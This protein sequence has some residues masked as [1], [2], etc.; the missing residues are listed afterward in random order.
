VQILNDAKRQKVK[1]EYRCVSGPFRETSNKDYRISKI[2]IARLEAGKLI[3]EHMF[4][5]LEQFQKEMQDLDEPIAIADRGIR[6]FKG[7]IAV[8]R[9][10]YQTM[11][12][13][14]TEPAAIDLFG[15]TQSAVKKVAPL[16]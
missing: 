9:R 1:D 2:L 3:Q 7:A 4:P 8:W 15:I 6:Q 13:G 11:A 16:P 5:E 12:A 10:S 14:I